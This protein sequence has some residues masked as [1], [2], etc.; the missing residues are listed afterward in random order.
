MRECGWYVL[1]VCMGGVY[2]LF[3]LIGD[4]FGL[5]EGLVRYSWLVEKLIT[6]PCVF[7]K[8]IP[9]TTVK[10]IFLVTISC[11]RNVSSLIAMDMNVLPSAI[12]GLSS[13]SETE[14]GI[15]CRGGTE[16]SE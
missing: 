3:V 5:G 13:S 7:R 8:P 6:P 12:R 4:S 9:N 16:E 14:N 15:G 10:R 2:G 1:G 11:S